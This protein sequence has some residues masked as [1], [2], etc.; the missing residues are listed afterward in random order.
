MRLNRK[1]SRLS[2]D[3]PDGSA[4]SGMAIPCFRCGLCCTRYQP[5]LTTAE[6]ET[7]ALALGMSLD[8]FLD[9]YIDDAWFEP[10]RFLLDTD[11]DACVFLNPATDDSKAAS[12]KIHPLRPQACRDWQA[13]LHKKEC[14]EGLQ[15]YWGLTATPSGKL[16]GSKEDLRR[17]RA[18]MQSQGHQK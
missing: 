10:G 18:F 8:A 6:A 7:I 3:S 16:V 17:F 13:S 1:D 2:L 15:R 5:P 4:S 9:R 14:L 11:T 12:C